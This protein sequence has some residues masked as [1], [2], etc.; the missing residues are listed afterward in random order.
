MTTVQDIIDM[1]KVSKPNKRGKGNRDGK[2]AHEGN[3]SCKW[4]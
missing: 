1:I 3:N 4:Y 2:N